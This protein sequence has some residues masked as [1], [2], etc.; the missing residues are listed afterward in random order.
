MRINKLV[1]FCGSSTF[2]E[3]ILFFFHLKVFIVCLFASS[4]GQPLCFSLLL[5]FYLYFEKISLYCQLIENIKTCILKFI[6]INNTVLCYSYMWFC[7]ALGRFIRYGVYSVDFLFAV[8]VSE[9]AEF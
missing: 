7:W 6:N 4:R 9:G 8:S 2:V 5:F 3:L 1:R